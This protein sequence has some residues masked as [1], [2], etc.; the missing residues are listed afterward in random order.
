MQFSTEHAQ[1]MRYLRKPKPTRAE[2]RLDEKLLI[3]L[4]GPNGSGGSHLNNNI[5]RNMHIQYL[6]H[7]LAAS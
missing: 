2:I 3:D 1:F 6:M 7:V 5:I 4:E